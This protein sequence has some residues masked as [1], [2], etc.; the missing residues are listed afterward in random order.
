MVKKVPCPVERVASGKIR[1]GRAKPDD[2]AREHG[3]CNGQF[4]RR[5]RT[6]D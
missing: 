5:E 1:G 2:G 3:P 4:E 6:R